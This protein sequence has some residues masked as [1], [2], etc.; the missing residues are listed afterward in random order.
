MR[1]GKYANKYQLII[2]F[3]IQ[4][5]SL[6]LA[7]GSGKALILNGCNQYVD[8]GNDS[9]LD[10]TSTITIEAWV[11]NEGISK[12]E[13]LISKGSYSL[14]I[15]SDDKP[16]VELIDDTE[17]ISEVGQFNDNIY[18][19]S[20]FNG[21]LYAGSSKDQGC[22]RT[23]R[24]YR[25]DGNELWTDVGKLG[26]TEWVYSL[27]V[28]NGK[29][30]AGTGFPGKV[31]RYDGDTT[32]TDVGQLGIGSQVR[33]LVVYKDVLYG[34]GPGIVYRYEGNSTWSSVGQLGQDN[35]VHVL[36]V[37]N[38][39]LYGGGN[40]TC[41]VYRYDDNNSWTE[42]GYFGS[43]CAYLLSLAIYN[44]KLYAGTGGPSNS[45]I[46]R[47]E[48]ETNWTDVGT[49]G[50]W[51]SSLIV[52]NGK[53][54]AGTN[55]NGA[56]LYRYNEETNWTQVGILSYMEQIWSMVVYDGKLY[57]GSGIPFS[58]FSKVF[59]IGNGIAAYSNESV[60][61]KF[62]HIAGTYNGDTAMVFVN[63][64]QTGCNQGL[65]N[66]DTNE[67]NLL[68]G[69]SYGSSQSANNCSG[70]ECYLGVIDE[71]RVWNVALSESKIRE[72][73]CK[74]LNPT[75]PNWVNL[76]CY[77]R[78]DECSNGCLTDQSENGK[79]GIMINMNNDS[80]LIWSG[81]AIGDESIQN[82]EVYA[83][84]GHSIN[85]NHRDGDSITVFSSVQIE[86][87]H[88]Y[89]SDSVSLRPNALAPDTNW[90]MDPVRYW[91]V[92]FVGPND[93]IYDFTYCYNGH[94]GILS[95]NDLSLAYRDDNS[96]NI[97][98]ASDPILNTSK[99][100]ITLRNQTKNCEYALGSKN[101]INILPA[102]DPSTKNIDYIIYQNYP[103]PFNP[104]TTISYSLPSNSLVQLKIF[105]ILGQEIATLVNE[106]KPSGNYQVAFDASNLSSGI[107]F[108]RLQAGDFVQTRKMILLK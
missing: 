37:Y 64:V 81:A 88:L 62:C 8:F 95:E 69:S 102:D 33:T 59:E 71:I 12:M 35:A 3:F 18:A 94:P 14:K 96:D 54:Y 70:D 72:W 49:L 76:K 79:M 7:Q 53:L 44:G 68:I 17:A 46:F 34:G 75:H 19:L 103:N 16:Y 66:M 106:E 104:A 45:K 32:W 9:S 83:P 51:I 58:Y 107:Y 31:Y 52:Y 22:L 30:Y 98:L 26:T 78:F 40:S 74:K 86:G 38:D 87:I 77:C 61:Q 56:K 42:V 101:G 99:N 97:W 108:Y 15:G 24:V 21:K 57:A 91:G 43:D 63:G 50:N 105:N 36:A 6:L 1:S 10:I 89:R 93:P 13:S 5:T 73:M 39:K 47:Y 92:Y 55:Q 28:Y 67:L 60:T 4:S 48:G 84:N 65:M 90:V 25:Y 80:S 41:K 20:V 27:T 29:L 100:T 11:K 2:I 82:Y 85:L 23:G